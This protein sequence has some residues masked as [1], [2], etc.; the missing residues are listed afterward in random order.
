MFRTHEYN[1]NITFDL[2]RIGDYAEE[3]LQDTFVAYFNESD[4]VKRDELKRMI[5]LDAYQEINATTLDDKN[6]IYV[7][8]QSILNTIE[9]N[10]LSETSDHLKYIAN[11][12]VDDLSDV[13]DRYS[14]EIESVIIYNN[15]FA[16]CIDTIQ[17]STRYSLD[18]HYLNP[19]IGFYGRE[20]DIQYLDNFIN[21][22]ELDQPKDGV[23][24]QYTIITGT[25]GMGKSK[26]LY[27]YKKIHEVD[28]DKKYVFLT[29]NK[30]T[31]LSSKTNFQYRRD[32]VLIVDYASESA[33]ELGELINK[34]INSSTV[35]HKIHFILL[36][37]EGY[38]SEFISKNTSYLP[39]WFNK[40]RDK[41][42]HDSALEYMYKKENYSLKPLT[43]VDYLNIVDNISTIKSKQLSVKDRKDIYDKYIELSTNE[44]L[45]TP[46][47]LILLTDYFIDCKKKIYKI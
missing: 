2:N 37:R 47:I 35:N 41:F 30:I 15:S 13:I 38:Q 25:G 7:C 12:V 17:E 23:K 20:K 8:V 4:F 32:L 14:K 43:K 29:H 5:Y 11:K 18:Y 40:F 10:Y 19:K 36:E 1:P 22:P 45:R 26:L 31:E 28:F 46:L 34:M 33:E 42:D 44:K 21:N 27:H 3:H 6:I 39:N 16:Q 9:D 24:V